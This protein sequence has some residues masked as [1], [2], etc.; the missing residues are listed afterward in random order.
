MIQLVVN[1]DEN[2]V[3]IQIL[4]LKVLTKI[5]L[6]MLSAYVICIYL[7]TLLT[8]VCVEANSVDPDQTTPTE[9]V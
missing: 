7:L 4:T 2:F 8:Y 6:K 9:A 5:N 1:M 3:K